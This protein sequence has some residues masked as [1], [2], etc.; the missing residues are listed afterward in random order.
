M[1][2]ADDCERV[3]GVGAKPLSA[4][5]LALLQGCKAKARS[6]GEHR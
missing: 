3:E 6:C 5:E 4:P 2:D 1:A